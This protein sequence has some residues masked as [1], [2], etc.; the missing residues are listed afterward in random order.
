ME[1]SVSDSPEGLSPSARRR[2]VLLLALTEPV[3]WGILYYA[4][5]ALLE[6]MRQD[7]GLEHTPLAASISLGLIVAGLFSPKVGRWIDRLGPRRMM[8]TGSVL[9]VIALGL[10]SQTPNL[11]GFALAMML[12]GLA[13]SM[14]LYEPAFT[15]VAQWIPDAK[16]RGRA[17]GIITT[18][19]GVAST[20][21]VPLTLALERMFDWR[22]AVLTLGAILLLLTVPA[23]AWLPDSGR[24]AVPAGTPP[25][26]PPVFPSSLTWFSSAMGLHALSTAGFAVYFVTLSSSKG[27]S[28][29]AIATAAGLFGL[30]QLPARWFVALSVHARGP[31]ALVIATSLQGAAALVLASASS[32]F[33]LYA[34]ACLFG[35]GNGAVTILRAGLVADWYGLRHY[36]AANGVV[37]RAALFGR[38]AG[39]FV[40]GSLWS[41]TS[42]V[43]VVF[44]AVAG[45]S[46]ASAALLERARRTRA[47]S[48]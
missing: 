43:M 10:W 7:L 11:W 48:S 42:S 39:P 13:Q 36:G 34:G 17:L 5:G 32:S 21:F 24:R 45:A 28:T 1:V 20:I 18:T 6:P 15:A 2:G 41:Q 23:H 35:L 38:A 47:A 19:G 4:I 29:A 25:E 8:T 30:M 37:A 33:V 14:T 12:A 46:A 31:R 26:R 27:F 3:S 44:G 40:A 16:L 22:G 9:A